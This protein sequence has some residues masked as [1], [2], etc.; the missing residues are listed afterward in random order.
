M[1]RLC[2]NNLTSCYF[3]YSASVVYAAA[4]STC[5]ALGSGAGSLVSYT[6]AAEQLQVRSV[7]HPWELLAHTLAL[8]PVQPGTCGS[9][10]VATLILCA[11]VAGRDVLCVA[12]LGHQLLVRAERQVVCILRRPQQVLLV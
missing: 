3:W 8:Q 12:R 11:P 9:C 7:G 4:N 6:S 2:P 10:D 5:G 1:T